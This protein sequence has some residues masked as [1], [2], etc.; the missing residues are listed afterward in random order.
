MRHEANAMGRCK[1]CR[2]WDAHSIDMLKG[3]CRAP[4]QHRYWHVPSVTKLKGGFALLDSFGGEETKPDYGCHAWR[5]G[6]S[7]GPLFIGEGI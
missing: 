5:F 4:N 2:Y 6:Q 3:D 1:T 7:D